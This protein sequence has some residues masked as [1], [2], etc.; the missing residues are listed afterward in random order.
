[1]CRGIA[2]GGRRCPSCRGEYNRA[3][4]RARYAAKKAASKSTPPASTET[5]DTGTA[6]AGTSTLEAPATAQVT[7]EAPSTTPQ[8]R[9]FTEVVQD[10]HTLNEQMKYAFTSSDETDQH[11]IAREL[12]Y[13]NRDAMFADFEKRSTA[14]GAE[15]GAQAEADAGVDTMTGEEYQEVITAHLEKSVDEMEKKYPKYFKVQKTM[16]ALVKEHKRQTYESIAERLQEEGMEEA[17]AHAHLKAYNND[18]KSRRIVKELASNKMT[19]TPEMNSKL[20]ALENAYMSRLKEIREFGG[21]VNA[22]YKS[23][24]HASYLKDGVTVFPSEW[25]D[26]SN[27]YPVQMIVKVTNSR[28]HYSGLKSQKE[29]VTHREETSVALAHPDGSLVNPDTGGHEDSVYFTIPGSENI[30]HRG[31]NQMMDG[32]TVCARS[33]NHLL[34]DNPKSKKPNQ[35]LTFE[36]EGWKWRKYATV[37]EDGKLV[38][39]EGWVAVPGRP[40]Y[41]PRMETKAL[42]AELTINK[43]PASEG[44]GEYDRLVRHEMSHRFEETVPGIAE[45]E[46]KFKERREVNEDGTRQRLQLV[47]PTSSREVGRPDNY[48]ESYTGRNYPPETDSTGRKYESTEVLSTGMESIFARRS[49]GLMGFNNTGHA[50]K[51]HRNFVLGL[52]ATR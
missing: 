44:L 45:M 9:P 47:T 50:D 51:D 7:T 17:D 29:K 21:E 23:K 43:E 20:H 36:S 2:E 52:L 41:K 30:K 18:V 48:V 10:A 11:H 46:A 49:G 33:D 1:M 40:Y 34:S 6:Y 26:K 42:A 14:I 4:Q 28:A 24:V 38:H 19:L 22:T 37:G 35:I 16:I 3:Y 32:M 12:G 25:L 13:E 5:P 27:N 31:R 39:T 15:I 8:L